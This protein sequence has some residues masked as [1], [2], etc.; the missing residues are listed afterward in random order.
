MSCFYFWSALSLFWERERWERY[1]EICEVFYL[2]FFFLNMWDI[3]QLSFIQYSIC[4]CVNYRIYVCSVSLVKLIMFLSF[5]W[6]LA[7]SGPV[8]DPS[9][10]TGWS[11]RTRSYHPPTRWVSSPN[12]GLVLNS[13]NYG[14][15]LK[16]D[17]L[18]F[19]SNFN[20]NNNL[21]YLR[22]CPFSVC[23]MYKCM[24]RIVNCVRFVMNNKNK[25]LTFFQF[26][27]PLEEQSCLEYYNS[28]IC[29][30]VLLMC[31][32]SFVS[33]LFYWIWFYY[34]FF[35]SLLCDFLITPHLYVSK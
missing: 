35:N 26:V 12:Q 3:S 9:D 20:Q 27:N 10:P 11:T 5:R 34:S 15:N 21:C 33:W 29:G 14:F 28:S 7:G 8:S 30:H 24:Y 17:I 18:C 31:H 32:C 19:N 22:I 13:E 2:Y 25:Y 4:M 1:R 16:S 6:W 23:F